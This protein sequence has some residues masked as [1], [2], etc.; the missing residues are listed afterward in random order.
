[1]SAIDAADDAA[2]DAADAGSVV[3]EGTDTDGEVPGAWFESAI[4]AADVAEDAAIDAADGGV[5]SGGDEATT[6]ALPS[7]CGREVASKSIKASGT[8]DCHLQ[9]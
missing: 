3:G 7:P 8:L 4:D 6:C 1:M 9:R 2:V 5:E